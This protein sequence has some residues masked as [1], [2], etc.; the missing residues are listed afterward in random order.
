MMARVRQIFGKQAQTAGRL[1]AAS[2]VSSMVVVSAAAAQSL[3]PAPLVIPPAEMPVI[4]RLDEQNLECVRG[5]FTPPGEESDGKPVAYPVHLGAGMDYL[6]LDTVRAGSPA[7][8]C[9]SAV[10]YQHLGDEIV[11]Q[12]Q[13]IG[14]IYGPSLDRCRIAGSPA[15]RAYTGPCRYGW[16]EESRFQPDD[17]EA[18]AIL[19]V[20]DELEE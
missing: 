12:S 6:V 11:S 7:F 5:R 1:F 9:D 10:S 15:G 16:V 3:R 20:A 18:G 8:A 13:W 4:V 17:A 14:V 19:A 2:F